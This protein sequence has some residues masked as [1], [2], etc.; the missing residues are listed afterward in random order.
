MEQSGTR[1]GNSFNHVK[2]SIAE[3][4]ERAAGSLSGSEE[5]SALGPYSQ[6]ASEWL[7]QSADYVRKFDLKQADMQLRRQIQTYPGRTVLISL[8]AG[9]LVGL[10]IRRR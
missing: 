4:L 10:W 8:A 6:Q 7:H 3:K 9:V 2:E 1:S 5:G